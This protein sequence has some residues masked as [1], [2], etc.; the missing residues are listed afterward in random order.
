[1][2]DEAGA[3]SV[4]GV[5]VIGLLL[6]ATCALAPLGGVLAVHQR[7][8]GAADSAALAAADIASGRVA[9]GVACEVAAAVAREAGS[10][11]DHCALD[12]AIAEVRLSAE[13]FGF[14]VHAAARAGPPQVA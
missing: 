14:T 8:Q 13:V 9:G 11:V 12:G 1:M 2:T 5:G 10:E 3:A 6:G 4:L 7:V